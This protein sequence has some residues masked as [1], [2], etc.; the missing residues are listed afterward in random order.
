MEDPQSASVCVSAIDFYRIKIG[1]RIFFE[2]ENFK[3]SI[4]STYS[5]DPQSDSATACHAKLFH[6]IMRE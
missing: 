3:V 2:P 1:N 4:Y 5:T 6:S